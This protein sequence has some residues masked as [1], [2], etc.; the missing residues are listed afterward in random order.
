MTCKP[1]AGHQIYMM[2]IESEAPC[3][4]VTRDTCRPSSTLSNAAAAPTA[5]VG[6]ELHLLCAGALPIADMHTTC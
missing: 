2:C 3:L 1:P 4:R 6:A 5:T